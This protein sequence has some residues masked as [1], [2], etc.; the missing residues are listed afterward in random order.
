MASNNSVHDGGDWSSPFPPITLPSYP[1]TATLADDF[2]GN[3][4]GEMVLVHN[5]IIRS[6]NA[7]WHNA[8]LVSAKDVPAFISYAKSAVDMLHEHH[9]TEEEIFFPV[10]AREG[11]AQIVE[12]NIEQH[13]AFHDSMEALNEHLNGL[14]QRPEEYDAQRMREALEKLGG[15]LVQHLHDE[16]PR[17]YGLLLAISI[18]TARC[19]DSNTSS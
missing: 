18:L 11:L 17:I 1:L 5:V 7:V 14:A 4:A 16:V 2:G 10:L 15:P 9:H 13:K 12:G 19:T 3:I 6:F 8:V